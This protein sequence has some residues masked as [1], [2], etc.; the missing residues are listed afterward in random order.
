MAVQ[1]SRRIRAT[2]SVPPAGTKSPS[3]NTNP[4]HGAELWRMPRVCAFVGLQKSM[5]YKLVRDGLFPSPIP[6]VGR[7]KAW[8]AANVIAWAEAKASADGEAG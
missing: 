8:R 4:Y 7:T 6:L 5:I 2:S 1:T 3:L